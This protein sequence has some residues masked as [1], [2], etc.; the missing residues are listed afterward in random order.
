MK[1]KKALA[2][3]TG[4]V[5]GLHLVSLAVNHVLSKKELEGIMPTGN[6]VNV[7]GKNMHVRTMGNGKKTVVL[8]P[9]LS[10][11]LPSVDFA[12]LMR[13]LSEN[14][15]VA[16]VEYFGYGFSDK[17]DTPRTNENYTEE[18]RA[19][20]LEAGL[21]PPYVLMPFSGSGIYSEYYA[22]KYPEEV[23]ALVLLDTTSSAEKYPDIP[24]FVYQ[25]GKAQQAIGFGRYV[26][27]LFLPK[28]MG[29]NVEEGYTKEEIEQF[30]KFCNHAYN[31]TLIEQN[32]V[33][34]SNINEVMGMEFPEEVPVLCLTSADAGDKSENYRDDHL[35]KLGEHA[36]C[37][38]VEG[39]NHLNFYHKR[40]CREAICK[41][42]DE[43]LAS[44]SK[45]NLL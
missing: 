33:F 34:P 15:T 38:V 12:P 7:N 2:I 8:L 23:E 44:E 26:N 1:V 43:F 39:S 20:L 5:V 18:I 42:L 11:P 6:L 45:E 27:P 29:I 10:M 36:Q 31:D 41:A 17:A 35:K 21:K 24:K 9:G 37:K 14:Y 13:E 28:M 16:C 30:F 22:T 32:I 4:A 3:A 40:E 25:L 19:G